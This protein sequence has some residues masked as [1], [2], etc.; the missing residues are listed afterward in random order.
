[1]R[2]RDLEAALQRVRPFNTKLQ[3]IDLEQ[4]PTGW[5]IAARLVHTAASCSDIEGKT[6]VDL[7]TGTCMLGIGCALLGAEHVI[8]LDA[9]IDAL[10]IARE[11]IDEAGV[12]SVCDLLLCD[13]VDMPL[14]LTN[15]LPRV[16]TVVMNPPFGTRNKGIDVRFIEQAIALRPRAIYSL[17]KS[18]TRKFLISKAAEWGLHV[19]VIAELRF[20]IPKMYKHHKQK[21]ADVEV[22]FI[23]FELPDAMR[24][25]PPT[26]PPVPTSPITLPLPKGDGQVGCVEARAAADC[27]GSA[28]AATD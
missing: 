3:K 28:L 10:R 6:V 12:D 5:H 20:D 18:S 13:V 19:E 27:A 15:G 26:P 1:M 11:N 21:I 4:F 16:D 17:H 2:L 7:G 25:P 23:R 24:H 9:D 22:D 8:G 14:F